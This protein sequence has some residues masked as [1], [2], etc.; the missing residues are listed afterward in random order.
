MAGAFNETARDQRQIANR[1]LN[2]IHRNWLIALG[3][4]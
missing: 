4:V 3:H 1:A 2:V